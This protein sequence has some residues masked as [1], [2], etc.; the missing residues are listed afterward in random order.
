MSLNFVERLRLWPTPRK[1]GLFQ[2]QSRETSN[3]IERT[4]V[5]SELNTPT[6]DYYFRSRQH[7]FRRYQELCSR[8]LPEKGHPLWTAANARVILSRNVPL[9]WLHALNALSVKPASIV[10]FI[11]DDIPGAH[12]D[13]SLPDDYRKRLSKWYTQA[14][15]LLQSL[16]TEVWVS[17]RYLAEKYALPDQSVLPPLQLSSPCNSMVKCFYHGSSSHTL[18]WAFIHQ[19]VTAVQARYPNTWFELIGDHSLKRRF[20]GVPRVTIIH[21]LDWQNY[22]A[23]IQSRRMDIGLVPLY[24][25]PFNRARSHTKML[26]IHRQGAIGIYGSRFPLANRIKDEEAGVVCE[27]GLDNWLHAFSYAMEM[28]KDKTFEKATRLIESVESAEQ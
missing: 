25:S 7:R 11:D 5:V 23:L 18:E 6:M 1:T 20:K 15:P 21:P 19:F 12:Q 14:Y 10:W 27:D 16:C 2:P 3:K 26:D 8:Q 22:Q 28:P 17:T 13:K 24:D 9:R 4:W